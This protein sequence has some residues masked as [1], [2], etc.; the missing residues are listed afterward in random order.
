MRSVFATIII[1]IFS[2]IYCSPSYGNSNTPLQTKQCCDG[3]HTPR[4]QISNDA[5]IGDPCFCPNQGWGY[6]CQ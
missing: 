1:F 6:S 5:I 4:C 3:T 2:I